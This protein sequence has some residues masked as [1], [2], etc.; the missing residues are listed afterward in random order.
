MQMGE[1][2]Y[3]EALAT[4]DRFMAETKSEKADQLAVRGNILYRLDR[5]D[6]AAAAL[7]KAIDTAD[8]PQDSW[9][10]L[11]M[12]SYFD[13]DKPMEAAKIAEELAA[14]RPDDKKLVMNLSSI[15][16]NADMMDKAIA[17][18]EGARAKGMLT[19]E[20]DYRQLYAL[21]LNT[22]GKEAQGIQIINEG[23]EK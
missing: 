2:H 1:E 16:A 5:F 23:L 15:Y 10:Q 22:E 17:V 19:E 3:V 18:I 14:K 13:Q 21:Y 12:A 4:I 7:R 11:L 8:K 20:R 9:S 6:E